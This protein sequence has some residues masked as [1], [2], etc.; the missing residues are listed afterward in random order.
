[1]KLE[2]YGNTTEGFKAHGEST[3]IDVLVDCPFCGSDMI[4]VE[5]T[6]S[7]YYSAKCLACDAEGPTSPRVVKQALMRKGAVRCQHER[8]FKQAVDLWNRRI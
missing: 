6:H 1:M 5:N 3:E 2:I 7:P 4:T 8:A